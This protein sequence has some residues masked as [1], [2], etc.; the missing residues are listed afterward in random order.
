MQ[1]VVCKSLIYKYN[2][3][4]RVSAAL[5]YISITLILLKHLPLG[6]NHHP[7]Q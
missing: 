5:M 1:A 7:R 6:V 4:N 3:F 2:A